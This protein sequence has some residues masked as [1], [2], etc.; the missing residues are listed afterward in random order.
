MSS[1]VKMISLR[2]RFVV[3]DDDDSFIQSEK[4]VFV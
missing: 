2:T 3:S 1:N 4:A